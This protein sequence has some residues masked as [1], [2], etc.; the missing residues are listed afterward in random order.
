MVSCTGSPTLSTY[1]VMSATSTHTSTHTNSAHPSQ[2]SRGTGRGR[3]QTNT[4]QHPGQDWRG[5]G[6]NPNPDTHSTNHCQHSGRTGPAR[7]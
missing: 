7:I 6:Q 1:A 2:E 3:R 5:E 4:P